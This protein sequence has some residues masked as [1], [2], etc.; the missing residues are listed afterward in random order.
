M[1]DFCDENK[2]GHECDSRKKESQKARKEERKKEERMG[3][4]RSINVFPENG[5]GE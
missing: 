2:I 1:F 5:F 4:T 3:F